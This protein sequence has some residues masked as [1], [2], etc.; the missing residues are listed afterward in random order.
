M[1]SHIVFYILKNIKIS[2]DTNLAAGLM[3]SKY[4]AMLTDL[5]SFT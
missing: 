2:D 4:H 5:T 3:Y 1:K